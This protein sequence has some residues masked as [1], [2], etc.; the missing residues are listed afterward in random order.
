MHSM[1]GGQFQ[2]SCG[3]FSLRCVQY[4]L[5]NR[6]D[7]ADILRRVRCGLWGLCDCCELG[8][9]HRVLDGQLQGSCGKCGMH[10][11]QC[12]LLHGGHGVHGSEQL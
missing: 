11:L 12:G 3:K 6:R 2:G 8:W 7:C 9:M 1:Y 5:F 4:G 10:S